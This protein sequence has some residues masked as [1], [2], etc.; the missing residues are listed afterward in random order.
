[1]GE[2][3]CTGVHKGDPKDAWRT[4]CSASRMCPSCSRKR[5]IQKAADLR[6]RLQV[7]DYLNEGDYTVGV[8]TVTLPGKDHPIRHGTL[9]EQYDYFTKRVKFPRLPGEH[10]MRGL[11]YFL[12]SKID[13]I[14]GRTIS[15]IGCLGG[16]HFLEFKWSRKHEWWNLHCHTVFWSYGKLDV[17]KA[18]STTKQNFEL[19]E[20]TLLRTKINRGR[21]AKR[22]LGA[23]GFGPRYTLDYADLH[24]MDAMIQY[25]NK[26]AYT[27]KPFTAPKFKDKEIAEFLAGSGGTLPRLARPFG[28][29]QKRLVEIPDQDGVPPWFKSHV[30]KSNG[31]FKEWLLKETV[32]GNIHGR[33][34][35]SKGTL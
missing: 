29:A 25:S 10:S 30:A 19:G 2:A 13:Q 27:T 35:S 32:D 20:E 18:T 3:V 33:S 28:D 34:S 21:M 26:V 12:T 1:M 14:T 11:N 8:L 22:T 9:Q 17:L 5:S 15:G 31:L 4:L 23:L 6:R 7:M 16:K 24:E